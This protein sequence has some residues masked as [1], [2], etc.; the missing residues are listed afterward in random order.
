EVGYHD[1]YIPVIRPTREHPQWAGTRSLPWTRE[2]I[3]KCDAVII[4]TA[5]SNVN[6]RELLAWSPCIIDT[7]NALGAVPANPGQVWKA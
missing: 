2:V 5:H 6:H 4:A 3:S 1:P 7:R